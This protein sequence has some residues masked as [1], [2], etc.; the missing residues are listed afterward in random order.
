MDSIL[1]AVDGSTGSDHAVDEG[2]QLA[3]DTGAAVTFVFVRQP[4]LP[5]LGDPYYQR[6]L[7]S[8]LEHAEDALNRALSAA[9]ERGIH[10]VADMFE[11]AAAQVIVDLAR[12]RDVDLIVV[13]SRGL[14][15]VAG[16]LLG[17]VS[18]EV[19]HHA[20]RPVLVATRRAD[21][22]RHAA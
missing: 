11:G 22:R 10:A 6:S 1:I 13:G 16:A 2:L 3:A 7:A 5:S 15:T 19:V 12:H 4:P 9:E 20:D 14:G 21:R 17:S 8:E 18:R